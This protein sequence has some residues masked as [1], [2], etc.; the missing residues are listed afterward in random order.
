MHGSLHLILATE[1]DRS[2]RATPPRPAA[3]RRPGAR[4]AA[5]RR[6][7]WLQRT[8]SPR[9]LRRERT[10]TP[11]VAPRRD[12]P[13]PVIVSP[14]STAAPVLRGRRRRGRRCAAEPACRPPRL[15]DNGG[16]VAAGHLATVRRPRRRA[17]QRSTAAL[18]RA[19]AGRP[20]VRVRRRRVGRRQD[21]P[22]ARVR[23]S[24]TRARARAC[25]SGQ[26]LELGGAQIPYAPLVGALRP[27]A[28]DGDAAQ[29]GDLPAATRNALAEL[30]P[31]LGGKRD[32]RRR[33]GTRPPGPAVRGA[34]G[35]ARAARPRRA[36]A[37]GD[38][39]PALG[40][41]LDA[42]LHHLPGAQR[43][44][45]AAL[46]RRD[47]SLRRAAPAPPAAPAAGRA[48]A[49]RRRRAARARALRPRRGRRAAR[50]HPPGA[51]ARRRWP[52]GSTRARRAT[53]STPRS[54]S[55]R[56][57]TATSWL[58][59]ETLRDVLLARVERLADRAQAVVRVAAV[60]DRP[61]HARP[62]RGGRRPAARRA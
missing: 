57:R 50:G 22:A 26:C 61:A 30:L 33:G 40:R 52:S 12:P 8:E 53:R 5:L 38:R 54:C 45:G 60:L 18:E 24:R 51:G 42:R 21:A 31:E 48:R 14:S 20:V 2:R 27:L 23:I 19:A 10:P 39:G 15:R 16:R 9:A 55:P 28:R 56:R 35:A 1:S 32:A 25:C 41:R 36:G 7:G 47:L 59:P 3:Q 13:R 4:C 6:R 49:R 17:R 46:P 34:A 37:A 44:R 43:A 62:A 11:S 29:S 58:L